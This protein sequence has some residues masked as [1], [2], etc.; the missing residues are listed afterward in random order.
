MEASILRSTSLDMLRPAWVV[1][2]E[3]A[4]ILTPS[5]ALRFIRLW[6]VLS[7]EQVDGEKPPRCPTM[8]RISASFSIEPSYE[9]KYLTWQLRK[10]CTKRHQASNNHFYAMF[11]IPY[12]G[13]LPGRVF[14]LHTSKSEAIAICTTSILEG[15]CVC[16]KD[17]RRLVLVFENC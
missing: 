11:D 15:E 13:Q 3:D 7:V 9:P 1:R 6:A 12:I 10:K 2:K 5:K 16:L 4:K 14:Q 17:I 8:P